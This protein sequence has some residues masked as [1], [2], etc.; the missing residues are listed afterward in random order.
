MAKL[1]HLSANEY[2]PLCQEHSTKK[3]WRE[4]AKSFDE[5]HILARSKDNKF[6]YYS[7]ENI[8]LHLVPKFGKSRSF[9]FTSIM[10]VNIIRKYKI[11]AILSQCPILGGFIAVLISKFNRIPVMLE[12]HGMEYFRILDSNN[13]TNK[14]L[15]KM[16][17]F[18]FRNATKVRSLNKKMTEMLK[19]RR[20]EANIVVIPNRVDF[21]IFNMP[22]KDYNLNKPIKLISVG[23]FVWEKGYE[24]AIKATINLSKKYDIVLTLIGGG[25]LHDEYI[26][27]SQES[28]CINLIGRLQQEELVP[29]LNSSDIYIQPSLSEGMPR[30]IIEAMAMKLP[31][32]ASDVGAISGVITDR[33]NGMLI[34][35]GNIKALEDAIETLINDH[36]LREKISIKGYNEVKNKYEWNEV[37]DKYRHEIL[38]MINY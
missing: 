15:A 7:E 16:L 10:M 32:I 24:N 38:K 3:I 1:L 8:H 5:Y 25:P 30:T 13:F 27:L 22:K 28:N 37:F 33:V 34:E 21:S 18:S 9:F 35:S 12:I 29:M 6:H 20:V 17:R 31:V 19:A 11:D 26:R 36:E 2:P 23:R 14:V 4:L